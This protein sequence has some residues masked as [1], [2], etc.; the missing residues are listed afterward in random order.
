MCRGSLAWANDVRQAEVSQTTTLR[1]GVQACMP[2]WNAG[3]HPDGAR[4]GNGFALLQLTLPKIR[5]NKSRRSR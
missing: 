3:L 1:L 5:G 4:L 2:L